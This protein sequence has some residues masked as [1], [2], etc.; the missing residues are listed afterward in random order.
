[1]W[2]SLQ[3]A[4]PAEWLALRSGFVPIAA[5][6]VWG[7]MALSAVLIAVVRTGVTARLA[8]QPST[9]AVFAADLGIEPGVTGSAVRHVAGWTLSP[10]C[11]SRS[12]WRARPTT[13][14][15][16]RDWTK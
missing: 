16:D 12:S 2:L 10:G 5:V 4:N 11:R 6:E 14:P 13:G 8:Q 3:G 7:V 1:M 9:A 15:G